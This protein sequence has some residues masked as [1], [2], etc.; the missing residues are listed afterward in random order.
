M[1]PGQKL[2]AR[3]Y[4]LGKA[5]MIR[6]TFSEETGKPM[7]EIADPSEP[8]QWI[9]VQGREELETMAQA[10]F[11]FLQDYPDDFQPEPGDAS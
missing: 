7:L 4:P 6:L 5:Q 2:A 10:I 1:K 8:T 11:E 9:Y 3:A